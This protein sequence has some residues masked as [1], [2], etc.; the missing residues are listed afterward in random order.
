MLPWCTL[1]IYP[2][3][4]T[5]YPSHL[6]SATGSGPLQAASCPG[7][8]ASVWSRPVETPAGHGRV[9]KGRGWGTGLAGS[10]PA[11]HHHSSFNLLPFRWSLKQLHLLSLSF[12]SRFPPHSSGEVN[13]PSSLHCCQPRDLHQISCGFPLTLPTGHPGIELGFQNS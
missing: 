12:D 2:F 13:V 5:L 8:L 11:S 4:S 9:G 10:L 6:L 3:R 1:C 7:P